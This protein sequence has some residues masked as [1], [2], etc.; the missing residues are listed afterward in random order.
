MTTEFVSVPSTW[1]VGDALRYIREVES[2]RETIY[3]IYVVNPRTKSLVR[4]LSLRRLLA[5]DPKR[6]L[7]SVALPRR[8]VTV[9]PLVDREEVARLISKYYLLAVPVVDRSDHMLGIVT[10]DDIIDA[11]VEQGT[12]EVQRFGG[13][14]ALDVPYMDIGFFAMIQKRAGWLSFYS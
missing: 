7:L 1:T 12:K 5:S 10:V 14:E 4:T 2:T 13:V 8:P 11:I 3:A 9:S 6:S